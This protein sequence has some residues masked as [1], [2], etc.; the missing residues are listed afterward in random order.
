MPELHDMSVLVVDCQ[1]TGA[2]PALGA[3][4]EVGWCVVTPQGG[5]PNLQSHRV[6][7]PPGLR[8]PV[9]VR[10][11]TG[12]DEARCADAIAP[13]EAWRRLCS[14]TEARPM[15]TAIHFAR[16]ELGFLQDW[17]RRFD[18][19]TSFPFTAVCVHAMAC[20][21]YRELPRR[22]LRALA[23]HLG[24]SLDLTR[25]ALGHVEATAFIWRKLVPELAPRGIHT[26]AQ[27]EA[28]LA[29]PE[30][31]LPRSTKRRY[32]L[33]S[34]RYKTLPD[35][36]GV[37]Q[38]ARSNGDVLYIGKAASLKKRVTSHFAARSSREHSIE[39][40]TQVSDVQVTLTDSALEAALLENE[41]I[42]ALRPPYNLQLTGYD[43]RAWFAARGFDAA[44]TVPDREHR[45][46]PLP[47]PFSLRALA[48]VLELCTGAQPDRKLRA[49]AVGAA[50]RWAPDEA[51]FAAGFAEL[52]AQQGLGIARSPGA[53][54]QAVLTTAKRLLALSKVNAR[55]EPESLSDELDSKADAPA[56]WDPERVTRHVVRALVQAYQLLRRAMWLALLENSAV[57]Y[58]EPGSTRTRLIRVQNGAISISDPPAAGT[59]HP[60]PRPQRRPRQDPMDR[61]V[62]DRLRI[63]TSELKRIRRD[64]GSVAIYIAPSR[65]LSARILDGVFASL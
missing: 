64:G 48:A 59:V 54:R 55:T 42:K 41:R 16:F 30:P 11:L 51:V 61:A 5:A 26:W 49:R 21:L 27:L 4:L 20:R 29:E 19:D 47:S 58:I 52:A 62:Y 12:Y 22:S 15:P 37:Y 18:P 31:A 1:T 25:H 32:P 6:A 36:P 2:T 8:V 65:R 34:D 10:R 33:P 3:V 60:P 14:S 40:L 28:W 56:H 46:G 50:E 57:T 24:Y 9:H 13:E 7:L 44:S 53:A 17:A 43:Q 45:I 63:L 39:M 23:G 35:R 38:F